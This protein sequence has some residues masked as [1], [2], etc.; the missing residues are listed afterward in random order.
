MHDFMETI[1]KL[2]FSQGTS[3]VRT[4][5]AFLVGVGRLKVVCDDLAMLAEE[6]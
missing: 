5:L 4:F 3:Q 1:L 2:V 6:G